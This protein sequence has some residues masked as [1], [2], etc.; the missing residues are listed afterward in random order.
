MEEDTGAVPT[1]LT[2]ENFTS[3]LELRV[4]FLVSCCVYGFLRS[5]CGEVPEL[6]EAKLAQ[7]HG[8]TCE[9]PD[10]CLADMFWSSGGC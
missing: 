9:W 8:K 10:L 4:A 3:F 2:M 5:T 6:C 7:R 1:M